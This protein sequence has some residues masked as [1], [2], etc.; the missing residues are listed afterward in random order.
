MI[1]TPWGAP[2]QTCLAD[3]IVQEYSNTTMAFRTR[4]K[5][6][7]WT[8]QSYNRVPV[9]RAPEYSS[10]YPRIASKFV[11]WASDSLH[12]PAKLTPHTNR[13]IKHS[14][15]ESSWLPSQGS[16]GG[17]HLFWGIVFLMNKKLHCLNQSLRCPVASK[18][19]A[20]LRHS[21]KS[22]SH[23]T[24]SVQST[25]PPPFHHGCHLKVSKLWPHLFERVL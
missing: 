1:T 2:H 9:D 24:P 10:L 3:N 17:S 4:S 12:S 21:P 25:V 15:S 18:L 19:V 8:V 11:D 16:K 13:P 23:R 14:T 7:T 5:A 6:A 22:N 20:I